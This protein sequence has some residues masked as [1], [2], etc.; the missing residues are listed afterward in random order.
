MAKPSCPRV[1]G[2]VASCLA[3][4]RKNGPAKPSQR[5]CQGVKKVNGMAK[6]RNDRIAICECIKGTL[7]NIDYDP[8]RVPV[9]GKQCGSTFDLPPVDRKT[10]C[11][12]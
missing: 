5:C 2:E 1:V 10:N 11:N 12:Q 9:L 7:V 8:K 4:L 3:F 6:T